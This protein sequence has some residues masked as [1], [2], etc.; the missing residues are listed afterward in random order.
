MPLYCEQPIASCS[1]TSP[2]QF[3]EIWLF[4]GAGTP[5]PAPLDN[6]KPQSS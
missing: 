2:L 6:R 3:V 4:A 1:C 5:L